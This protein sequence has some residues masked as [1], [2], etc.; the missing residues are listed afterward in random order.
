MNLKFFVFLW[1]NAIGILAGPAL[2]L[3]IALGTMDILRLV[4]LPTQEYRSIFQ[5]KKHLQTK[6]AGHDQ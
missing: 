4:T 2:I 5:F 3:Y 1:E 6:V